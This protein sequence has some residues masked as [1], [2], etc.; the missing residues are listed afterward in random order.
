MVSGRAASFFTAMRAIKGAPWADMS[1]IDKV[2]S[3]SLA[4]ATAISNKDVQCM[5]AIIKA[6]GVMV[7][8]LPRPG[9]RI[10]VVS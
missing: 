3:Q 1:R 4:F 8:M 5:D 10:G 9:R 7:A 2:Q 6:C